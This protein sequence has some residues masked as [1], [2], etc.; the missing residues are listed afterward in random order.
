M[1]TNHSALRHHLALAAALCGIVAGCGGGDA[2]GP[3]AALAI[4]VGDWQADR[5]VVTNKANANQAP[6]LI[7]DLGAQFSLNVQPSG[8]YTAILAYQGTPITEIGTLEIV[9]G[10]VV[11]HV[12]YPAVETSRSRYTIANA[13]LTLDGDTEFDFNADG[14]GDAA[15]AHIELKK[16]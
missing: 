2:V 5:F 8:Q 13:R 12:S 3:D 1:R 6:E 9:Q 10:D 15:L 7:H 16:R 14:K 4:L 11:F